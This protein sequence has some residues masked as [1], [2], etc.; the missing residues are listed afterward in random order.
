MDAVDAVTKS[1]EWSLSCDWH[2][3]SHFFEPVKN[4]LD[5]GSREISGRR[6][7]QW[8]KTHELPAWGDVVERSGIGRARLERS[9]HRHSIPEGKRRL[10][11][12]ADGLEAAEPRNVKEFFS[13]W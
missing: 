3:R 12:Y 1:G 2:P 7:F 4:H 9:R 13:I 11:R 8:H 6:S 10:R 5:L